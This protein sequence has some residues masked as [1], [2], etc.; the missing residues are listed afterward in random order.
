MTKADSPTD[1]TISAAR[2]RYFA[3]HV[4]HAAWARACA[5]EAV[6]NFIALGVKPEQIDAE[7]RSV[8]DYWAG[9]VHGRDQR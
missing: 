7:L 3:D 1:A 8:I 9:Q 2:D 4:D 6:L 5:E